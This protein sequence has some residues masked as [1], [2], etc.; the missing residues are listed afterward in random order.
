MLRPFKEAFYRKFGYAATNGQI[1]YSVAYRNIA[2]FTNADAPFEI[3]VIPAI[4]ASERYFSALLEQFSSAHGRVLHHELDRKQWAR[5][6]KDRLLLTIRN[7]SVPV[8]MATYQKEGFLEAGVLKV[9]DCFWNSPESRQALF[10]HF[11]RHRDQVSQVT[12][13]LP[14]TTNIHELVPALEG[15]VESSYHAAPWMVRVVDVLPALQ[16]LPAAADAEA[17]LTVRDDECPWNNVTVAVV[18]EN[19]AI[20]VERVDRRA[21]VV[22]PVS[23]LSALVY[24]ARDKDALEREHQIEV[25]DRRAW[26]GMCTALPRQPLFNDYWF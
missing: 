13:T 9:Q 3:E 5:R 6:M 15:R 17:T 11:A 10:A 22:I 4:D 7:G 19:H 23:G 8:A 26:N 20:H 18:A 24:G 1:D 25:S 21:D 14:Y 2:Q 12:I 16:G